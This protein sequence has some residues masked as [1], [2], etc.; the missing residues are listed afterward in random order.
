MYIYVD[1]LIIL[2]I[3]VNYFLL[4]A[5]AKLTHTSL[6]NI[7]CI[8]SSVI[9]SMFS[10]LIFMPRINLIVLTVLR[11]L[12]AALIVFI[13]FNEKD[14]KRL[15]RLSLVF[16]LVSFIFAGIEYGFSLLSGSSAV[17]FYNS[18]LYVNI[19]LL[20]LV[21]STIAAYIAVSIFRYFMDSRNDYDGE[22]SVVITANNV[23]K[24]IK[25]KCDSCNNLTDAFSGKPIIVCDKNNVKDMFDN[26]F[27]DKILECGIAESDSIILHSGW[28]LIPYNTIN[29]DGLIP[30][31][32]PES[33]YINDIQ[34]K[35][36]KSADAYIG[37]VQRDMDYAIFNPKI[38][39]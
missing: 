18:V 29:S 21:V 12:S 17:M 4:K 10:L 33:V 14:L 37:V 19:S 34:R 15:C 3:Y 8:I 39:N 25:A 13:A 32:K 28:R 5:T 30:C 31:F 26:N 16:F 38:M 24:T 23:Q 7:R 1:I 9:G 22:Y 36:V 27:L 2:N 20:T 6:K 35:K 11:I